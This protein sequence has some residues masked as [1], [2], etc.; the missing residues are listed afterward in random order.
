MYIVKCILDAFLT[1]RNSVNFA[2]VFSDSK[3]NAELYTRKYT[4]MMERSIVDFHQRS[5]ISAIHNIALNLQHV[6]IIGT[7]HLGNTR[8][9]EFNS[10]AAYQDILCCRDYE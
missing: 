6:H 10:R 2:K 4:F 7:H 9:E 5:Y 3:T 1:K 8:W